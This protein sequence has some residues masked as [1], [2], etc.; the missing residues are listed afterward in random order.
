MELKHLRAGDSWGVETSEVHSELPHK[1]RFSDLNEHQ[2][3]LEGFV[4]HS[5]LDPPPKFLI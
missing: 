4:K 5:M 1:Q 2:N 3:L